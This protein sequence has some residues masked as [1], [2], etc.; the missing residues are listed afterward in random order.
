MGGMI[1]VTGASGQ[2]GGMV[3]ERLLERVPAERVGVSVRDP[4][5]VADLV[6]RGVRV[7]RGDYAD[8]ESLAAAFEGATQVFLV[9]SNSSGESA[10]R[11]HRTAIDAAAAA[12]VERIVYTSQMG[13]DPASPFAPMIDHAHTEDAL[14][15]SGVPFTSLRNGFYAASGVMLFGPAAATGELA[16]PAD[17]PVAW[18]AHADLAEVAAAAL[19]GDGGLDGVTPVLTGTEAIDLAGMAAVASGLTGREIR[20]VVVS[21]DVWRD[22]LVGRGVPESGADMLLGLFAASRQGA[23]AAVDPT[24]ERV[25]GRPPTPFADVLAATLP[26]TTPS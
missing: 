1:V 11:Q 21:D 18:T 3:V 26:A 25:L 6:A 10:L 15:A 13:S 7:R 19:A 16:A 9:S 12:G 8:P 23:F 20:R 14:R 22:G 5:K 24:L 17:G 2:L 4:G